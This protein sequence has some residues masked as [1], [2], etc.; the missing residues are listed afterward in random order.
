MK[1]KAIVVEKAPG[2]LSLALDLEGLPSGCC[3]SLSQQDAGAPAPALTPAGKEEHVQSA[4]AA[5]SEKSCS[6]MR[7]F[8][9]AGG[10]GDFLSLSVEDSSSWR[11][12]QRVI[13]DF[14]VSV[15]LLSVLL[16][17]VLPLA[18]AL[19]VFALVAA[20]LP[21]LP[22]GLTWLLAL[23][24]FVGSAWIVSTWIL[25]RLRERSVRLVPD[26]ECEAP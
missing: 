22:R 10:R 12:G 8:P 23:V 21:F 14:P 18:V 17:I 3:G 11:I 15:T 13:L 16:A 1:R 9:L 2:R 25:P 19:A 7:L 6:H 5:C 20:L 24:A 4:C 26:G